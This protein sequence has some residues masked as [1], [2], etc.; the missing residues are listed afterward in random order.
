M[1]KLNG[2]ACEFEGSQEVNSTADQMYNRLFWVF[3]EAGVFLAP[4][5]NGEDV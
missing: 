2:R 1:E 5:S 3:P 4:S